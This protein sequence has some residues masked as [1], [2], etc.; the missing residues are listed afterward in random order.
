MSLYFLF[1]FPNFIGDRVNIVLF[2]ISIKYFFTLFIVLYY[3]QIY[4]PIKRYLSSI[5]H[6]SDLKM[7][8]INF[9]FVNLIFI[10]Y[11]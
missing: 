5:N 11:N 10:Q 3:S 4:K 6:M 2:N 9:F 1:I 8:K 7:I